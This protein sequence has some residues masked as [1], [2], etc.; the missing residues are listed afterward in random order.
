VVGGAASNHPPLKNTSICHS[1]RNEV[2]RRTDPDL[3]GELAE[4][5]LMLI[6][7]IIRLV[8]KL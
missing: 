6:S 1:E 2:K 7:N 8:V 5:N 4:G 3:S